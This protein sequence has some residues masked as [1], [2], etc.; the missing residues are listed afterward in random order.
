MQDEKSKQ[1]RSI[2]SSVDRIL[3]RR[4]EKAEI[5]VDHALVA[6]TPDGAGVVRSNLAPSELGPMAIFI[7]SVVT[8]NMRDLIDP[9]SVH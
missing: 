3:R 9:A 4:L 7:A 8:E 2:L 6:M 1:L 5:K